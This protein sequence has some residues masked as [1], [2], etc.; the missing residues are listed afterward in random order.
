MILTQY[1]GLSTKGESEEQAS[2]DAKIRL[3]LLSLYGS[4]P[5]LIQGSAGIYKWNF[6]ARIKKYSFEAFL[7]EEQKMRIIVSSRL[8]MDP[9]IDMRDFGY[10]HA[11]GCHQCEHSV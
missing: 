11:T 9:H 3:I 6:K 2:Q 1:P 8:A 10:E 7:R 4:P 5:C